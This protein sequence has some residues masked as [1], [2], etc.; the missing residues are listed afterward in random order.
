MS[1]VDTPIEGLD[2]FS[3]EI[4]DA[5]PLTPVQEGMLFH[6]LYAP[7]SQAYFNQVTLSLRGP[8]DA[9]ALRAA[10]AGAVARHAVLRTAFVWE[11]VERPLQAVHG[12]AGV[13]VEVADWSRESRAWQRE[14]RARWLAADRARGFDLSAPPLMRAALLRTAGDESEL[15]WS[16]HHLLLDGWS[17]PLLLADVFALY[18]A[19]R[20]GLDAALPPAA[21]FRGYVEWLAALDVAPFEAFWRTELA[22]VTAPTPLGADRRALPPAARAAGGTAERR[23]SPVV[24]AGLRSWARRQ[25]LTLNTLVQGAWALLLSRYSGER[26]VVFG[27]TLAGRP[28]ELEGVEGWVGLFIN[29]LPLRVPVDGGAPLAGWLAG[30]Q[31]RAAALQ[32]QESTPLAEIHRWSEVAPGEPLFESIVVFESYP[33]DAAL[34]GGAHGF[35]VDG[36]DNVARTHYPLTL[37]ALPAARLVLR[38][39]YD[40]ARFTPAAAEAMAGHLAALLEGMAAIPDARL[41]DLPLLGADERARVVSAWNDTARGYPV[42]TL[43]ALFAAQAARTPD[44]PAV[45]AEEGALSYAELDAASNRLARYLAR[46]GAGVESR[47]AVA[48]ERSVDLP[49]ALLGVM[50]TGAAYVPIDPSYPAERIAYMLGDCGASVVLTQS[51]LAAGLPATDARVIAV[52]GDGDRIS[53]ESAEPFGS[54]AT[55]ESLAYVIYTSGSTGRPKGAM[56]AHGGAANRLLWMQDAYGLGADDVV[57]QKTPFSFDV[58]VWELFWP[59]LTGAKLVMARPGMHGD[60]AYLAVVIERERVTTIHFVPPMLGAFLDAGVAGRCG[61]LRRV[62]CSGEALPYETVERFIAA[63]PGTGLHNLYGPTEAAVDVTYWRVEANDRRAVPIGRP[64]ANTQVYVVDRE[65]E[66]APIGIPGELLIGGAQVGRGYLGRPALTAEKFVPDP[67]SAIPGARLYR[68]GDLARWNEEGEVEFAGR[69]DHQ[70]KVRGFRIEPGEIE[71]VLGAHPAVRDAVVLVR[72]D[73]PGERRIVAYVTGG[74]S[75]EELREHLRARLP[76]HMVPAAFVALDALPL[77]PNG[78]V[79]RRALPAPGWSGAGEYV[80]PRTPAEAAL[81]GLFAEVLRVERVGATD[82]FFAL[83]GDSILS[84][85]VVARA[86]R[87]GLRLTPRQVFEHPT[88]RELAAAAAAA[89]PGAEAEAA[90]AEPFAM[91]GEHE[92]AAVDEDGIEDAYPLSPLQEGMLFHAVYAP[93]SGVYVAQFGFALEGQLD[94]GA[95]RRAWATAV[96][97]HDALRAS[98]AWDGLERP[99][100]RIHASVEVPFTDDDWSGMDDGDRDARLAA[101][102]AADRE[103][104]FVLD[105]APLMRL[106]LVRTGPAGHLLVWTHHHLVVDGWS[107]PLVF[108]DVLALYHGYAG[109]REVRLAPARPYRDFVAWLA[110]RDR[111]GDEAYWRHELAGFAE[112]TA[113]PLLRP[114]PA[115]AEPAWEQADARLGAESAGALRSAARARGVTLNTLVQGAWA[116]ALSRWAGGE[117]VLFGATASGRPPELAGIEE[118][119]G[120][121][122][123]TL[124]LRVHAA[125]EARA[126]D[127]LAA[128]QA[129]AAELR[130]HAHTPLPQVQRWSEVPAGTPL[131][132][133][134]VVFENAPVDATLGAD[135]GGLRA[136]GAWDV[137]QSN[138]PLA[139]VVV[140]GERPLLRLRYDRT[141]ADGAHAARMLGHVAA[142]LRAL[143]GGPERR[144]RDISLLSA[145]ERARV[146][147][148]WNRAAASYPSTSIAHVFAERAAA[149]PHARAVAFGGQ[150][151]TYAG[152]DR[153]ANRVARRLRHAGIGRGAAVGVCMERSMETVAALLGVLKA[154]AAYVPLDPASPPTRIALLAADAGAD[155]V[156]TQPHLDGLLPRRATRIALDPGLAALAGESDAPVAVEAGPDDLAYV[157]YTSGST[158]TPKGVAIPHRAVLRLA[159]AADFVRLGPGEAVLHYAPLAFDASTFELWGPLLTGGR[160]VVAPPRALT[161]AELGEVIRQGGATTLWLTAGL[162]NLVADEAPDAFAGVRQVVAG[163]DVLSPAHLRRVARAYPELRLVNGYGPTENTTFTCCRAITA[164]DLEAPSIPLGAPIAGT[165]A[166]VLDAALEPVPDGVWGE[167]CAGGDGVARGYLNQPGTTAAQFVP[168]PF[169]AAPGARLYRTGD[170][171]R[172]LADGALEFGGRLDAQVKVRGFRIEPGEVETALAAH[173]A[174]RAAAAAARGDGAAKRLVAWVAADEGTPIDELRAWLASRLPPHLVPSAFVR[175]DALPLTPNGKVDRAALPDPGAARDGVGY[176]EPRTPAEAALATIWAE[177]LRVDRVGVDDGFFE[178]GGDSIQ[179]LQIVSR[180]R[181]AGISVTPRQLFENPT[182][183]ALARVAG[184]DEAAPS[185]VSTAP[186]ALAGVPREALQ[187]R[188]G[189]ALDDAYPLSPM[190]EGMLFHELYSPGG[191]RVYVVQFVFAV[192]GT[193][194]AGALH[195]AWEGAVA[196]HDALRAG[197]AWEGVPRPLQLVHARVSV[198]FRVEDWREEAEQAERLD[199]F[200]RADQGRGFSLDAPPL[201][202]LALF[203]TG[204]REHRLVWTHHHLVL[205]GWSLPLIFRDVLALYAAGVGGRELSLAPARP[206]REHVAW[207]QRQDAAAAEA[208]W[209]R[210]LAGFRAATPL[211]LVRPAPPEMVNDWQQVQVAL[212]HDSME[213]LRALAQGRGLTLNTVVQGAWALLLSR[214]AGEDDVL[215]GATVAGRPAEVPGAGE[216]VGVFINTLPLRVRVPAAA[217]L[218]GWLAAIQAH[219]VEQREHE[220]APLAQVQKWSEVPAGQPL[221]ETL[222]VFENTPFDQRLGDGEGGL[223]VRTERDVLQ[224]NY[225]VSLLAYPGE[226]LALRIRY[227]RNRADE[228]AAGRMLGHL[229]VLVA[230]FAGSPD[231]PLGSFSP[232]PPEERAQVL[233]G[234]NDTAAPFPAA[235]LHALVSAQAARTPDAVAV[236]FEGEG[237][238]FAEL[239]ARANRLARYLAKRGVGRESRVA[240][241]MERSLELP[242]ALLGVLKA[243]A[244]YVPVDPSYPE[245]RIA[246]MLEDSGARVVLTQ[247]RLAA[248]L[249]ATG[250]EV[251][252]V[253]EDG[254]A[255]GAEP[256]GPFASPAT[257]GSLAYVIYTSGSTGRP[258]GAMNEHRG[259]VNRLLWAQRDYPLG[260]GDV[261]LQKT[262]I[263]FDVSV[264]EL[265]APLLA[266][267]R[268]VMARPGAHGDPAYLGGVIARERITHVHFVAP[269]LQAFLEAGAAWRCAT[270]RRVATSGEALPY[271]LMERFFAALPG[272]ELVDLYGPTEAAVEVTHW[273][274]E[275]RPERRVVPIG[276]PVANTRAYVVDAGF[277]PAGIGIPGELLLAGVQVARGYLGRPG[278]TAEK[279]VPD[280]FSSVPGARLY[281][282]GD[283]ARWNEAGEV[284]FLGRTDHQVK[285]R[286]FRIE[287]GEIEAELAAHPGVREAVVVVREDVPGQKRLVAYVAARD[288]V[289]AARLRA[290][291]QAR[292]PEYMVPAAFGLLDALPLSPNGKVDRRALPAP[293]WSGADEGFVAPRTPAEV[294][295]AGIWAD[296]L[297]LERVGVNDNFFE[298]GGDSILSVQVVSRAHAA[299]LPLSPRQIFEHATVAALAAAVAPES[300][301]ADPAPAGASGSTEAAPPVRG[302][303]LSHAEREAMAAELAG[304]GVEDVFPL[305]PMQAGMLFHSLYEPSSRVY[306]TQFVYRLEGELEA[307]A[308]RRA[309]EGAV[310]RHGVLRAGFAW[311]G[312]ERPLQVVRRD[313]RVP[314][315]EEDWSA[316][317]AD[318]RRARLDAFLAE[319]RARGLDP[320]AAPLLRLALF[321]TGGGEHLLA[322]TCHHAVIDGWSIPLVLRD[323]L[324]LYG[325]ARE[326]G[327]AELPEPR[328]FRDHVA[329]L[330]RQDAA[331]AEAEW[332][333]VLASFSAPT[334]LPLLR[335]A[336][337]GAPQAWAHADL[338]LDAGRAEVLRAFARSRGVTL[339][340]LVQGA[341]ALLLSRYSGERDVVFGATVSGRPADLAGVEEM[342]GLFLNAVPVRVDARPDACVGEW[343]SGVQANAARLREVEHTPLVQVQR[344]SEVPGGQALFDT[345]VVFENAPFDDDVR[346]GGR[347]LRAHDVYDV[348][349]TNYPLELVVYPHESL[350]LRLRYDRTRA[351]APAVERML[352][353]LATLLEGMAA[354]PDARLCDLPLLGADERARVVSAWNDT[355][356]GYP[357]ATLPALFAA[358]AARTPDAAAVAAEDGALTYAEL[359]AASNQLARHLARLGA[360]VE[361]RVAVAMERSVDLPVALLGV[362]KTGAAYVPIDPSYPAERIAYMLGDCGASIVLTQSRLAAGLPATDAGVISVDGDGDRIA[363]ESPEPFESP[364]TAESLAYVIHTS[365]S[366]GRPKGAMNAHGGVANRLLWM[367]DAYGLGAD[368]VVL[369]KTPFSFDVSVWELFWPLLAGAKLVMARP[370]MHGDPAYLAEVI[371]RERVTTIHFVPPMLGAFLDAGVAGR[372]GSLRRVVCSGE[373]LPYET[374]ERFIAALPGTG[375]H[376]LYGPTEAAVDVTYWRVEANERRAVP[377]GRPVANTQVYVVDRE[378]DPAPIGIPGE[379]LIG[380]AQVGR[381]YLGRPALT[382][383]KFVPDPF[384]TA[385]GARLYRTGDLARWNEE[386]EVEFAGRMDHQGKV[387]GFRIEPGEIEAVLG[388]HPAVRDAVV[389]V[390]E[391]A[392]GERRI[393]AYVTG[394]ASAAE[395]REHLRTRLP[396]H[397]VPAAFVA[398][399]ALPLSPNGKVDRRAL[400]APGWSGAGEYLAPRTPGEAALAEL[401]AEVLRV[402]RV[403]ATDGFFALGGDSIL[404]IQLVSRARAA[405]LSLTPRQVFESP[406]VR[407]L[408]AAA[409][410]GAGDGDGDGDAVQAAEP[411]AL[412]PLDPEELAA[413]RGR[414][415]DAED[416]L[417]LTPTQAGMLFHALYDPGSSVYVAQFGFVLRGELDA[418][419]MRAAWEGVVARHAALRASFAWEGLSRPVQVIH[420]HALPEIRAEDWRALSDDGRA[421]RLD[422]AMRAEREHG[423]DLARAPLM[424]LLLARTAER[425]HRLLWT[426]HHLLL[427]G[428]SLPVIFR[429]VLALYAAAVEGRDA[430][431]PP[432]PE[433]RDHAAWLARRDPERSEAFWRERLEGLDEATPLPLLRPALAGAA[434]APEQVDAWLGEEETAALERLARDHGL[435]PATVVRGAWALLLSRWSGQEEVVLGT[436]VSGRPAELPRVE[437]RVGLFINTLPVRVRVDE[438]VP[439]AAWLAAL[440]QSAAEETEHAHAPLSEVQRWSEVP[441]GAPLFETLFAFQNAPYDDALAEPAAGL[442]VRAASDVH[443]TNYPLVLTAHPGE[444]LQLRLRYDPARADAPDVERMLAQLGAAL[445]ACTAG[446]GRRLGEVELLSADERRWLLEASYGERVSVPDRCVHELFS[447]QAARTPH[448]V[449][450]ESGA[451]RWSY[452]RLERESNRLANHLAAL[453]VGPDARV[454]MCVGRSPWVVATILGVLKAG[455]AWLPL[456]PMAPPARLA[457][458]LADARARVVVAEERT[459]AALAAADAVVVSLDADRDV[460]AARPAETPSAAVSSP[461]GLAYVMYTSGST[462]TPKA[463]ALPHRAVV[464][465][466]HHTS[467]VQ[468]G[469]VEIPA[470]A[471]F[472]FDASVKQLL[473][474]L[475]RGA[476]VWVPGAGFAEDL[477]ALMDDL[478][479]RERPAVNCTPSVWTAML[480]AVDAAGQA[481]PP[482][483][484]LLLGGEAVA[485]ALVERTLAALPRVELWNLYGPT[486]V[487]ANSVTGVVGTGGGIGRPVPNGR[488]YVLD[489]RLRPVPVGV[490]GELCLGGPGVA[491]GYLGRPALTAGAFIPDPFAGAGAR[492]YRTGDRFRWLDDGTLE[493]LG[494]LDQQVKVRGVRI[495]PG[496][497]EAA[498]RAHPAVRDAAVGARGAGSARRLVAWAAAGATVSPG[499]LREHLRGI[500]PEAMVPAA[501][502]VLEALPLTRHGKVDRRALPEPE[503]PAGAAGHTAPRGEVE[504]VL[505]AVWERVLNVPRVGA[506]DSF[507]ELGGDSILSIQVVARARAAGVIVTPRQL[508]E[509]PTVAGLARVAGTG[510]A[511]AAPQGPVAGEA[512]LTPIQRDFFA[513]PLPNRHHFNQSVVLAPREPLEPAA[514]AAAVAA[515]LEHHDALRL[516]FTV[517]DG[518]W[519]QAHAPVEGAEAAPVVVADLSA[520]PPAERERRM[521]EAAGAVQRSLHLERGPLLRAAYFQLG[522]GDPGRLL[523]AAHHLVVDGVSWRVLLEDLEAAYEAALQGRRAALPPKTTPFREWAER[524][525]GHAHAP[526]TLAEAAYWSDAASTPAPALPA[527]AG[528]NGAGA[529]TVW[530]S[531]PA[532]ETAALLRDV[533][534][535]YR[536]QVN[537]VLLAALARAFARWTGERRLRVDLEGHGR[538]E[539]F[540]GVDLSRTV[541]WFTAVLP[542]GAGAPRRR[543][544]GR[545]AEGGE[546]A[547]PRRS[548]TAA[549]GTG[550]CATCGAPPRY[551]RRWAAR[552]A[553][554]SSSTTWASSAA[555]F[556][557]AGCWPLPTTRRGRRRTPRP[558]AGTC[559][560]SWARCAATGWRWR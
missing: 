437:E 240:V 299:G 174:V 398:L 365:G 478:R 76:E 177:V 80:A 232:L 147:H 125:P 141:R 246:F 468:M 195:R 547:A 385:S 280:P 216:I 18:R 15:V 112:P 513:R 166:Y 220:H 179:T 296:V 77:S 336:P 515:L 10:W 431:L 261:L 82:G 204:E 268:M 24:T 379:L 256:A 436:I 448:A 429:D 114:E 308:F 301:G 387:R 349:Q 6:A 403:G 528:G 270:L 540:E 44:A 267:A 223:R 401:F 511:P 402:E 286:G 167:L 520:V 542:G 553:R 22:G 39:D 213:A 482:L 89:E 93:R 529:D 386:G 231:A 500:L 506:D 245:G 554:R 316:L 463:V 63:L 251:V 356:R 501:F 67:F 476:A 526:T 283:R 555:P 378:M 258:K 182:V 85:Q 423:L 16:Y 530:S 335:A 516:R 464:Q 187:A 257:P 46:L 119:V 300:A 351:A 49:V 498:L 559:S 194:D 135:A 503:A 229:S 441:A 531:L 127:W 504:R 287:P 512:P 183:A 43:P 222:V 263:S 473:A 533:P 358:Q 549:S 211:P 157:S 550:C 340:T 502:V 493:F 525:A 338:G 26:A 467:L 532:D 138:Y 508:F 486:E 5:Y 332:R 469:G 399:E 244:A 524:L 88:V 148:G 11:G 81:A 459:R 288:G 383:E 230:A 412:A 120:M 430:A 278:L 377:I 108:R 546:G 384:S 274:C 495:E 173:P 355:A 393:V 106:T 505:A 176:A 325:A 295:L 359:D 53:L 333:R 416:V 344:W 209:R 391:D 208:F 317:D 243:G 292:L 407:G 371:E 341:W 523:L 373:A 282:T 408:A 28:A 471:A 494:R 56:N 83:G 123:D 224:T 69:M 52:D 269:M 277:R 150:T 17:A 14:E 227:D 346:R 414:E 428:W 558:R 205:D 390:R 107:L 538:E 334:S 71:A 302:A 111:Q 411:F 435:T 35:E 90:G 552:R 372:C 102:L 294:A 234:W 99:I 78:K 458:L 337:A 58:S 221:F 55:A 447:E 446:P 507:F 79:D 418:D 233:A 376:N 353:H 527:G 284:E 100:Q 490:P 21:P 3:P 307:G 98:F 404:S 453:G 394:D 328:P 397:M 413:L 197:F 145:A 499:E 140:P 368:D 400:P 360:G 104:G 91:L 279:F 537:D 51:R 139:L 560:R 105:R 318:A 443:Q 272:V 438:D 509:H 136:R 97:R 535:A 461:D 36:W 151:L 375:L 326:G 228:A 9:D 117:E 410:A 64:V 321:R 417:P 259:I 45:V 218:G 172:R 291:L 96:K 239:E 133:T 124:P 276:R 215:F 249:P 354:D 327:A 206:Y 27:V 367:Q 242:V 175:L 440:Q 539:L 158:G 517:R 34:E 297:R 116:L 143:A 433:H 255:I 7:G 126:G 541:G 32:G 30:V 374:A 329:W 314:F 201:M 237:I 303:L 59:L 392:P 421:A 382:A 424:R 184:R 348:Q 207:L 66:P 470:T 519:V 310:S 250:A 474:P 369:Q 275:P 131:F 331:R 214:Y 265:F 260:P 144:L 266:G 75:A 163:G 281:R 94:A 8:V 60:P 426:H 252:R 350:T 465:H 115:G 285:V 388:A 134:L 312:L 113:L 70:G 497:V 122:I 4:E 186:F 484:R 389:L 422:A 137:Q 121:F 311:E 87:A 290:H 73:A 129:H 381:G 54:P 57:L 510:A 198:P 479:R 146:V 306:V 31:A 305:A 48:M 161:A 556:R 487:A 427:D 492:M 68:T 466:L 25:G 247:A 109:G 522:G 450:V 132:E 210:A 178:L 362:M 169:A 41:R 345:L 33:V 380:G 180:A 264:P 37:L 330:A 491:R 536:T 489:R 366:T 101:F 425:E 226:R 420:R 189:A 118:M 445:A 217:A 361:S 164:A 456:D 130:E 2:V 455:G 323:V 50:K 149:A 203:R 13:E 480:D 190:Q 313:V 181:A 110:R 248:A 370:G 95:L 439:A 452:A 357:V 409:T 557:A 165:T 185:S 451:E 61:S 339:N 298:L 200:L 152:L 454:G 396:E 40:G 170:R 219:A 188:A 309:W 271:E 235:T 319:D 457:A 488:T 449:A 128:L 92:R 199:A 196:R 192:E 514:L 23:L 322:W 544:P 304:E 364:A 20:T 160:V 485:P 444:R 156:L 347:W 419:A 142:A 254:P 324:A 212:S 273:R 154:G 225:P 191:S 168:D 19:A 38:L 162:F 434:P 342:V 159:C 521:E 29:T 171:V 518:E 293:E 415:A 534:A 496:E 72:E 62:V 253:D 363:L 320:A 155:V 153:A 241:A 481:P 442:E 543:R 405:G 315:A 74:A 395:L 432:A 202:R 352:R 262:P 238:P 42:A 236:A 551:A 460:I 84:L 477:V 12:A 472:T 343:L 86:H 548:P 406:T 475:L 545:R 289:D 193:V 462:G 103:R 47:V 65:L 483:V 1:L